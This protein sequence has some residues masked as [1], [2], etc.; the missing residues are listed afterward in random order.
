M[1]VTII[2]EAE[3]PGGHRSFLKAWNP[4]TQTEAWRIELPGNWPGG[5]MTTAG[6]LVFQGQIDGKLV[7]RDAKTGKELWSYK[8][9]S[10]I[11]GAPITYRINNKQYVTVVTGNGG[12]GAGINSPGLAAYRTDY[13]LPRRVLTFALGGTDTIPPVEMPDLVP[14]ADPDFTPDVGRAQAGAMLFGTRACIV[15][16][17]WNAIGGGAAPD[18]RY[19]PVITDAATFRA[20]VRDGGLRMNGMPSFPALTDPELETLRFY[21]RAR[22]HLAPAEQKAL[23]DRLQTAEASSAVPADFAGRW[24]IVIQSPIGPQ[25]A[26]MDLQVNGSA[27]AGRVTA[28]QGAVDV[29]GAVANG[30]VKLEGKASMP[31]PITIGYDLTVR[32]GELSGE[33]S[34]GPF[35]TFAVTGER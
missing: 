27:V 34:N 6:N 20:I 25:K 7:A 28:D 4:A 23:L 32:N 15:C 11:V 2:P 12:N 21:L 17:G 30:R 19:S 3:L 33:N 29:T 31:M 22:A 24:S 35:G 1:G 18:L 14:P 26:V 9:E 5:V 8:T 10:P 13:R 16:H